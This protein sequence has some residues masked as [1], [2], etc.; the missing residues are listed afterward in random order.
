M[1][2]LNTKCVVIGRGAGLPGKRLRGSVVRIAELFR[3]AVQT[4]TL[5]A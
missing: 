3:D 4:D 2:L 1:L 5:A